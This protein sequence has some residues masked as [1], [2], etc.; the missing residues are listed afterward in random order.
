MTV[1]IHKRFEKE[2]Q[3]LFLKDSYWYQCH[4][5]DQAIL[6]YSLM[7]GLVTLILTHNRNMEPQ[8]VYQIHEKEK[9][10]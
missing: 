6:Q 5:T 1:E 8:Q 7:W 9:K 2:R 4:Y 10:H 3:M